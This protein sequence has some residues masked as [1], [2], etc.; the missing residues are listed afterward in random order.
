MT[1]QPVQLTADLR[2]ALRKLLAAAKFHADR[3][4]AYPGAPSER[5]RTLCEG[6]I[7]DALER[8]LDLPG[9]T[10][11]AE[12][13]FTILQRALKHVDTFSSQERD[14]FCLYLEQIMNILG[15]GNATDLLGKWRYGNDG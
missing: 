8:I 13:L 4:G 2:E 7:N 14:R 6:H 15:I 9:S 1:D 5:L 12:A 3:A 10:I 11:R